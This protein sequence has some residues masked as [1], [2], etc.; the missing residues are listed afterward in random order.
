MLGMSGR[1]ALWLMI[2]A[3]S[4]C[5]G[6]GGD[7]ESGSD[8]GMSSVEDDSREDERSDDRSSQENPDAGAA[9]AASDDR[10]G[11]DEPQAGSGGS[12][13]GDDEPDI[14]PTVDAGSMVDA[15]AAEECSTS[16]AG[17]NC[18]DCAE[19]YQDGDGDGTCMP[20]CDATGDEALDC[21]PGGTCQLVDETAGTRECECDDGYEGDLC[22]TCG[23]G[24]EADADTCVL[25]LP[26][27]EGLHLWLDADFGDSFTLDGV[28]VS[29]WPT[30]ATRCRS[31]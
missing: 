11:E 21:G 18:E 3:L 24:F 29:A 25:D 4:G 2:A 31:T 9:G 15:A 12:D 13:D 26:P 28:A 23:A 10:D 14:E 7:A 5:G 22:E 30:G 27:T 6:S 8:S 1:I 20:G 19:G 17:A 16:M